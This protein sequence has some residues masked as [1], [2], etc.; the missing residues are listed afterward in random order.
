MQWCNGSGHWLRSILL[1]SNM[2][3]IQTISH[4]FG[5]ILMRDTT[6]G[7]SRGLHRSHYMQ[8]KPCLIQINADRHK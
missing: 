7:R 1:T 4:I 3:Y 6:G 8:C 5:I 2:S